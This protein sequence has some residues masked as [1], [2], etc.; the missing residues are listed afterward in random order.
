M[1]IAQMRKTDLIDSNA[2]RLANG[3]N[4]QQEQ[5]KQCSPS[6]TTRSTTLLTSHVKSATSKY[7]RC[8]VKSSDRSLAL[9]HN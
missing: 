5:K 8:L 3:T 7:D 2:Q 4:D 1:R 9:I 6:R